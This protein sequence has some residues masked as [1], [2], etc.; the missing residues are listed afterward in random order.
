M[1]NPSRLPRPNSAKQPLLVFSSPSLLLV[2]PGPFLFPSRAD[3]HLRHPAPR[4]CLGIHAP[5]P[6]ASALGST[7]PTLWPL[8]SSCRKPPPTFPLFSPTVSPTKPM[9]LM[10]FEADG[11]PLPLLGAL[12]PPSLYKA[13]AWPTMVSVPSHLASPS[14]SPPC[15]S[16]RRRSPAR[17]DHRCRRSWSS[18]LEPLLRPHRRGCASPA[19]RRSSSPFIRRWGAANTR[20]RGWR[21]WF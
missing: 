8:D 18:P 6:S 1:W 19:R 4:F 10:A 15:C 14:R 13:H 3:A 12:S 16:S 5:V 11:R 21:W 2:R 7:P 17:V 20:T 9:P